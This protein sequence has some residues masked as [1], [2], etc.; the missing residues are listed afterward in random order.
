[1][2]S[3]SGPV[4]CGLILVGV[5]LYFA[6]DSAGVRF[7]AAVADSLMPGQIAVRQASISFRE[8]LA[9]LSSETERSRH[10]EVEQLQEQLQAER[11]RAVALQLQLAR[12]ADV[13]T[14]SESLPGPLRTLP[15]LT[16]VSLI[17]A[18][19]LGSALA[20]K[21]RKGKLLDRG[22]ANGVRESE[23]VLKSSHS[24]VDLGQ[25]AELSPEDGMLLGRCVI[26]K[27]ERVG[28]WTSTFL[29]LTD[30]GYR[31]RAQ[32]VHQTETGFVYGAKGILEGQGESRCRLKGIPSSESVTVGDAVYTAT[33]EGASATPLY[34]GRVVE[35]TLGTLDTEWKVLVEPVSL[36]NDLT[37][38]QI[39]R[40]AINRD[41]LSA[42]L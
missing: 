28:R 42:G 13:Q 7:R 14:R 30:A 19:V 20:E 12:Q 5:G 21:W 35:A 34:Y 29:L 31:G 16:S 2:S 41:R 15:R 33:R 4:T 10:Q 9:R 3:A 37:S 40:T 6:P 22:E 25:D 26:G 17:D 1:M 11:T 24:L 32:L 18:R 27:I 38:V 8:N 36:P 39:L 23:L